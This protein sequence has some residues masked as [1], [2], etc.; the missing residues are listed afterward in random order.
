MGA[1]AHM[2]YREPRVN[3]SF[4]DFEHPAEHIGVFNGNEVRSKSAQ[5]SETPSCRII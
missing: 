5:T 3:H 2:Q 1:A 4:S